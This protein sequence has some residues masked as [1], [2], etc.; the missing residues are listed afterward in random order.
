MR[1]NLGAGSRA[2]EGW[3]NVDA[4]EQ[5]GIDQVWDLDF[6]PWPWPDNSVEEI[7][8]FDV[9]E[10]VVNPIA[11][12]TECHR[13]LEPGGKLSIHT[14]WVG[15][16]DSF[17]DPTHRRFLTEQSFDYWIEGTPLHE[18]YG[19]AYGNVTFERVRVAVG[20]DNY[21]DVRLVKPRGGQ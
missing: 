19:K 20:P 17:T 4:V 3:V 5:D 12:M 10:H 7:A 15:N 9:F 11:F 2:A 16:P 1:L 18:H 14:T 6:G 13:I 21:L 8:A